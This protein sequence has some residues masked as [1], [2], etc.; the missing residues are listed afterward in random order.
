MNQVDWAAVVDEVKQLDEVVHNNYVVRD[1]GTL[2]EKTI[3]S[4]TNSDVTTFFGVLCIMDKSASEIVCLLNVCV[5][6]MDAYEKMSNN[7][8]DDDDDDIDSDRC[9]TATIAA[10]PWQRDGAALLHHTGAECSLGWGVMCLLPNDD[11]VLRSFMNGIFR[12]LL[13]GS[14]HHSLNYLSI[15]LQPDMRNDVLRAYGVG[16]IAKLLHEMGALSVASRELC[17]TLEIKPNPDQQKKRKAG[18]P[19]QW[20]IHSPK[21]LEEDMA[22]IQNDS[23]ARDDGVSGFCIDMNLEG[24]AYLWLEGAKV[25][26]KSGLA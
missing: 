26:E 7:G 19:W 10:V 20:E 24:P 6:R 2:P 4:N 16:R 22:V 14:M 21:I 11:V 3:R 23:L 1:W 25:A 5:R 12:S 8:D 13:A 15:R 17:K 18:T 9:G